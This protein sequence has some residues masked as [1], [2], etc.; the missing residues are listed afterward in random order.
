MK[1]V[2]LLVLFL[3]ALSISAHAQSQ[4]EFEGEVTYRIEYLEFD[5]AMTPYMEMLPR[6][7]KLYIR[8]ELSRLEQAGAQGMKHVFIGN[9]EEESA[10]ISMNFMGEEFFVKLDSSNFDM[11]ND[12]SGTSSTITGNRGKVLD[13]ECDEVMIY[14]E[15]DTIRSLVAT[16]LPSTFALVKYGGLQGL[17]L[18][19]EP[20]SGNT[21]MRF[22]AVS[23]VEKKLPDTLFNEPKG[24]KEIPA[25][26]FQEAFSQ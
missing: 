21:K 14:M 15:G 16:D 25:G 12:R 10:I 26:E 13:Y 2:K 11:A 8:G 19:Y 22:T 17:P 6:E 3:L 7:S 9:S 23:I 24:I 5:S 4:K 18:Q 1:G 20:L